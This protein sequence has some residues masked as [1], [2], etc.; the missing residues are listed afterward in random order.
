MPSWRQY[1]DRWQ[2]ELAAVRKEPTADRIAIME[3]DKID[4]MRDWI[5]DAFVLASTDLKSDYLTGL[6]RSV[7]VRLSGPD[8]EPYWMVRG[9]IA[10]SLA[11]AEKNGRFERWE[12]EYIDGKI[13][14]LPG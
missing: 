11:A 6:F 1:I 8:C 9:W 7:L 2:D 4:V 12:L 14:V 13:G 5:E 3:A 10:T